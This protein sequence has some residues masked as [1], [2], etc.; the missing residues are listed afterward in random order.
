ML[1]GCLLETLDFPE[2][3]DYKG[4]LMTNIEKYIEVY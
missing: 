4:D 3:G 1:I 2:I